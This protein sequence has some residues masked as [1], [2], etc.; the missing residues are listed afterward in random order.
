[1]VYRKVSLILTYIL[2]KSLKTKIM[3]KKVITEVI[4]KTLIEK[5]WRK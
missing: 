4:Y 1:M 2:S 3:S 5:T